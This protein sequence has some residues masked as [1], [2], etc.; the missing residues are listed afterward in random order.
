VHDGPQGSEGVLRVVGVELLVILGA[1]RLAL[2]PLRISNQRFWIFSRI[3]CGGIAGRRSN[4]FVPAKRRR[5]NVTS[6]DE[7]RKS[8]VSMFDVAPFLMKYSSWRE[9]LLR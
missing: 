5:F 1:R 4:E 7:M 6:A 2:L 3:A 9:R 8:L